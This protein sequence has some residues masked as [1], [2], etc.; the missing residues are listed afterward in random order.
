MP[1]TFTGNLDYAIVA[2]AREMYLLLLDIYDDR[3]KLAVD[4]VAVRY[5][6]KVAELLNKIGFDEDEY[7]DESE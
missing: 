1:K 2:H 5:G 6:R 3:D 7:D 4:D